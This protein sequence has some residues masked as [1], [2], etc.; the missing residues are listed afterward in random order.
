[1]LLERSRTSDPEKLSAAERALTF[2]L[3]KV[4]RGRSEIMRGSVLRQLANIG[5]FDHD[6][7]SD[8]LALYCNAMEHERCFLAA[9]VLQE[10]IVGIDDEVCHRLVVNA[11]QAAVTRAAIEHDEMLLERLQKTFPEFSITRDDAESVAAEEGGY[12]ELVL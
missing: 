5:V 2:T 9:L 11:V 4:T 7:L 3:S 12:I 10:E 1:M 8:P 6:Y